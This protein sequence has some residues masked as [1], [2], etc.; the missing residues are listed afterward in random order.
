[1]IGGT[2]T[3]E[4]A[5]ATGALAVTGGGTLRDQGGG[6][7]VTGGS[8]RVGTG[9]NIT[10]ASP[11]GS[12]LVEAKGADANATT[13]AL[14]VDSG[15]ILIMGNAAN[16]TGAM[17]LWASSPTG[18]VAVGGTVERNSDG[19]L[20]VDARTV[21]VNGSLNS[22]GD[23]TVIGNGTSGEFTPSTVATTGIAQA[24]RNLA[25]TGALNAQTATAAANLNVIGGTLTTE[26]ATATGAL[27]VTGGG[28][29][30]DQGGSL[31]VTGDSVRVGTG[32]NIT[33]AAQ[34]GSLLVEAKGADANATASAL[35]VDSGGTL[36]MGN[37]ANTTGAMKLLASSDTGT[38]AV[39][40]TVERN[41]NGLLEIDARTVSVN[42]LLKSDVGDLTVSG[43]ATG[44]T[45]SP[46]PTTG[47]ATAGKNLTVQGALNA[48]TATAAANLDVTGGT[49]TTEAATAT[50]ALAVTGGG[51][52]RDQGGG[53]T[54]TGDSVRVGGANSNISSTSPAGNFLV[55]AKGADGGASSLRVDGQGRIHGANTGDM[56]VLADQGTIEVAGQGS[57]IAGANTGTLQVGDVTAAGAN[58]AINT[59]LV[60]IAAGG[61]IE[62]TQGTA[63]S[64]TA[65]QIAIDGTGSKIQADAAVTGPVNVFAAGADPVGGY[66]LAVANGGQ[67]LGSNAGDVN[68]HAI[69]QSSVAVETQ[70]RISAANGGALRVGDSDD[71]NAAASS[72]VNLLSG[73]VVEKTT[74][75][76][77]TVRGESVRVD[78]QANGQPS[79]IVLGNRLSA[80]GTAS[81]D[82]TAPVDG[83]LLVEGTQADQATA[84]GTAVAVSNGGQIIGNLAGGGS[85]TV[86][87]TA[88]D[89]ATPSNNGTVKVTGGGLVS[90]VAQASASGGLTIQ[91]GNIL[92]QDAGSQ[93]VQG[94]SPDNPALAGT[95]AGGNLTMAALGAGPAGGYALWI[96][97]GG[98]IVGNTLGDMNLYAVAGSSVG[99]ANTGRITGSN[100]GSMAIGSNGAINAKQ[101]N[102]ING[103]IIEKTAGSDLTVQAGTVLVDGGGEIN[104]GSGAK[105]ILRVTATA[106]DPAIG[107]SA[108]TVSNGGRIMGSNLGDMNV[109]AVAG[110]SL[111]VTGAGRVTGANAGVLNVGTDGQSVGRQVGVLAGGVIEKTAG[112]N[113]T[114][115]S[116]SVLVDGAGS[117]IS[118]AAGSKGVF[119][120]E[121]TG[122]NPSAAQSAL[123]ASNGGQIVGGNT[124][125]MAI[126][127]N[128]GA[129]AVSGEN[130]I[131]ANNQGKLL[132]GTPNL[133]VAGPTPNQLPVIN[134]ANFGL[135]TIQANQITGSNGALI[136][137]SNVGNF[138]IKPFSG[139]S[140]TIDPVTIEKTN[141]EG[142][143]LISAATINL[144]D[145]VIGINSN[146]GGGLSVDGGNIV[147]TANGLQMI[148][149][150][151][152]NR[153]NGNSEFANNI[154]LDLAT[155][156]MADSV[157]ETRTNPSGSGGNISLKHGEQID[158]K[159]I[160][161]T[162]SG[163]TFQEGGGATG[164]WFH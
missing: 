2:L 16:T 27:T 133:R 60:S 158:T 85:L 11:T 39:G 108:L 31:T 119:T 35:T 62:K 26:A 73:G 46:T 127:A 150:E 105:G 21:F 69:Q 4:A 51:T 14:T 3:T 32:S 138:Q 57:A 44:F 144:T 23:L 61:K 40:G 79:R 100:S 142:N 52:L 125:D 47:I 162:L 148:R 160:F 48:Q 140:L 99:V 131:R 116:E 141:A 149:S 34:T 22:I 5:T 117:T 30:R 20:E 86:R 54:V 50:V 146:S 17:Q 137:A 19:L 7:T 42:G 163:D 109:Y 104:A 25:V 38:V 94:A 81:A 83:N 53:L 75:G 129:I 161:G 159:I 36:I 110:S 145:T 12:L 55:E 15:G 80:T 28:T 121:A 24:G 114:V 113:L 136:G 118:M 88:T 132:I 77:L 154:A 43:N 49:L 91:G 120:V 78:G 147:L 8:V 45:P 71:S 124:G 155:L 101:V 72:R 59:T 130:A 164:G 111:R 33:Q 87:A 66:A 107:Q 63:L 139:D 13:S 65:G 76:N 10:Q 102:V 6:L 64:V 1:V 58:P 153:G 112:A 115:R 70:G 143:L 126:Q 29:L 18:T 56:L 106:G 122:N 74:G 135:A 123:T 84:N 152:R 89:A 67:I 95:L 128:Q 90:K 134:I 37:A 93:I 41:S 151:I 156:R 82:L 92:V 98:R 103:G 9:S 157:I 96:N 68:V 97:D